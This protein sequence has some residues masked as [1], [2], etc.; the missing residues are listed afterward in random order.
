MKQSNLIFSNRSNANL[1]STLGYSKTSKENI[2]STGNLLVNNLSKGINP[3]SEFLNFSGVENPEELH[4]FYVTF[5]QKS[6]RLA[7]K[8]D[9]LSED[10]NLIIGNLNK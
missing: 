7:Y 1:S 9:N 4:M 3:S 5:V 10:S 8:F 6:K 2:C